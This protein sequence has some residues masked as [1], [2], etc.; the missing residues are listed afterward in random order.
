M[1]NLPR[2]SYVKAIDVWMLVSMSFIFC[3]L[4]EL[5]I[6]GYKVKDDGNAGIRKRASLPAPPPLICKKRLMCESTEISP[7]ISQFGLSGSQLP[8]NTTLERRFMLPAGGPG[9]SAWRRRK[10]A[11]NY[12]TD[13][14]YEHSRLNK[15]VPRSCCSWWNVSPTEIDKVSS[16][17][18][19]TMF[20]L[21][22]IIYWSYYGSRSKAAAEAIN[23]SL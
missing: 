3:S 20:A 12:A 17:A 14:T 8:S 16:V 21:F 4:L 6:V 23:A 7:K 5:A 1:R 22:N 9:E 19:P 15:C 13:H 11:N 18:F 10:S 2:V